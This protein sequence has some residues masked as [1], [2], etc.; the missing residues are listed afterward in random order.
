MLHPKALELECHNRHHGFRS[1]CLEGDRTIRIWLLHIDVASLWP[2]YTAVVSNILI[3]VSPRSVI[4]TNAYL[5]GLPLR[6]GDGVA[7]IENLERE[8][9]QRI[10]YDG[11]VAEP[12]P[13]QHT[14]CDE[15]SAGQNA[16]SRPPRPNPD[17]PYTRRPARR[18][19]SHRPVVVH[20]E[21]FKKPRPERRG[22]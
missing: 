22:H 11:I 2:V 12:V 1:I 14:T 18:S 7:L 3:P 16:V 15:A 17:F 19:T 5:D 9:T 10:R 6:S 4:D 21:R 8:S 20:K 13:S